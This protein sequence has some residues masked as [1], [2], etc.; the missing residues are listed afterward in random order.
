MITP[1]LTPAMSSVLDR[2]R[3]AGA[4]PL[5]ELPIRQSRSSYTLR[6]EVLDLPR[7]P[8][9]RVEDFKILTADGAALAA[10]LYAPNRERLPTALRWMGWSAAGLTS[11]GPLPMGKT[12]MRAGT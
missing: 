12:A 6:S 5:H 8:L 1:S 9:A 11:S 3:R 7:A 4:S 10:R 2:I